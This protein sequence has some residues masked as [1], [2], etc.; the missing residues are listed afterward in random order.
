MP[1]KASCGWVRQPTGCADPI[2][3]D[4]YEGERF[5]L[6]DSFCWLLFEDGSRLLQE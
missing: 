2:A 3:N 6:E 5:R 4:E 1:R